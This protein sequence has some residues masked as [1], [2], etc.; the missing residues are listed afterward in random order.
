MKITVIRTLN[1]EAA[2]SRPLAS[3]R[4]W[5]DMRTAMLVE[6]DQGTSAGANATARRG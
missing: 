5:Y 2:L 4:G 1:L 6:I 3:S